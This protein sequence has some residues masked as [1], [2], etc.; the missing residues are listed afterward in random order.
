[1]A[2]K[3]KIEPWYLYFFKTF[4][5]RKGKS[6]FYLVSVQFSA[7]LLYIVM[8]SNITKLSSVSPV[9]THFPIYQIKIVFVLEPIFEYCDFC[10]KD[11]VLILYHIQF[12]IYIAQIYI[13]IILNTEDHKQPITI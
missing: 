7:K 3:V 12:M 8:K 2:L 4:E 6:P 13:Y 10:P 9:Y 5:L 11:Y 1:M